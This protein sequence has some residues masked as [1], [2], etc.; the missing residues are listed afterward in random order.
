MPK[1]KLQYLPM[2]GRAE[3]IRMFL[4]YCELDFDDE[5]LEFDVFARKKDAKLLPYD[6]VRYG[7][8]ACVFP[9][10]VVYRYARNVFDLR[11]DSLGLN[12]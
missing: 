8:P 6:Q 9:P 1:L 11:G 12:G 2:H 4:H 10:S 7:R 5:I 3:A